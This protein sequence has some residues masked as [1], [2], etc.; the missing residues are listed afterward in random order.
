MGVVI[1]GGCVGVNQEAD[2]ANLKVNIGEEGNLGVVIEGGCVDIN[3]EADLANLKV[4]I[5]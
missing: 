3:P 5:G 2:L 1:E 4:N